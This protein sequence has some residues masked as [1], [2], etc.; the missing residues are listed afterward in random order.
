MHAHPSKSAHAWRRLARLATGAAVLASLTVAGPAGTGLA[1]AAPDCDTQA[2]AD[3]RVGFGHQG[4]D[5]NSVSA[6][7]AK[8]MQSALKERV[9][10]LRANG[11]LTSAKA[12]TPI[13]I[14][15]YVHVLRRDDGT[16][17]AT[18]TMV[19]KQISV[20]NNAYAGKTSTSSVATPFQFSLAGID[21]TNKTSW[22]EWGYGNNGED[23][24]DRA[25][26]KALRKGGM[27]DL[28]LYI[29]NIDNGILGYATFPTSKASALDGVVLL[30][31]SLPGGDASPY[32]LG[33][34]APHEVGHWLG[35]YHT[36]Q[37]GCV[38]PGDYVDDTPFQADGDNIFY[39]GETAEFGN[40]TCT[41][42]GLDPVHNFMSY[43]DDKC[44]DR[45][46]AGQ[47]TR[48]SQSWQAFR[49]GK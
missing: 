13:T 35:L 48:M 38:A 30:T 10:K 3:A 12:A 46:T 6:R 4:V 25:A 8:A 45:F 44:L 34:T 41:Q 24:Q 15:T 7:Q 2:P 26:K 40:D 27:A 19:N 47:S 36:F 18:A 1:S 23:A 42:P 22:Y 43:G 14:K 16:G 20:L 21:Y 29:A 37:G 28:N 33:D 31:G 17:G 39:C 32:N 49:Q 11:K 9:A 5:P